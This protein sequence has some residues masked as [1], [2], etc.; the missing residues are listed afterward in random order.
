MSPVNMETNYPWD[1]KSAPS[2]LTCGTNKFFGVHTHP[3]VDA[4]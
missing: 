2:I 3:G 4:G 1:G